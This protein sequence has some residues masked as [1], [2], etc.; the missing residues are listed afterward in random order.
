MHGEKNESGSRPSR[1]MASKIRGWLRLSTRS[2]LVIPA[3]MPRVIMP[4]AKVS[5]FACKAADRGAASLIC[6]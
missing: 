4:P 5:P 6:R 3:R 1:T 2:E